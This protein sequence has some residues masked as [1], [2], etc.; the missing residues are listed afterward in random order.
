MLKV[1]SFMV[2]R[3]SYGRLFH[4]FGAMNI[5]ARSPKVFNDFIGGKWSKVPSQE[6]VSLN[7]YIFLNLLIS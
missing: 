5:K 4:N 3:M 7:C 6:H 1:D 2:I